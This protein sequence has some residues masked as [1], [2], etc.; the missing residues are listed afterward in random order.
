[1]LWL[2]CVYELLCVLPLSLVPVA[3]TPLSSLFV[4]TS[5]STLLVQHAFPCF[6]HNLTV[7]LVKPFFSVPTGETVF[8]QRILCAESIV[9]GRTFFPGIQAGSLGPFLSPVRRSLNPMPFCPFL[10]E[11]LVRLSPLSESAATFPLF[12]VKCTYPPR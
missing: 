6:G 12:E 7:F 8:C 9:P 5:C 3:H 10:S 1:V 4:A 11:V 2:P